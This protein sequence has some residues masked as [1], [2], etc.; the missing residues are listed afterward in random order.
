MDDAETRKPLG[1]SK[2][3]FIDCFIGKG[4]Q[5]YINGPGHM[6]KM[7]VTTIYSKTFLNFLLQNQKPDDLETR[8]EKLMTGAF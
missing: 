4:K 6:A 3:N 2:P 8:T 5:K 7:T 1:Q